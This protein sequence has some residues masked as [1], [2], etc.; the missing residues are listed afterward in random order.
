M[1]KTRVAASLIQAAV[2]GTAV[3][4]L[5]AMVS[6]VQRRRGM[7]RPDGCKSRGGCSVETFDWL[8]E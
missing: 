8:C 2:G 5:M 1:S 4:V 7:H 3:A 6:A